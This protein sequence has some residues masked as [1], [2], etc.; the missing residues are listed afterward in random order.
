V[1]VTAGLPKSLSGLRPPEVVD[2]DARI[3]VAWHPVVE[4]NWRERFVPNDAVFEEGERVRVITGPNMSGKSTYLR[5]VAL[6]ALLAQI[7]SCVPARSARLGLTD[8][9][10]TR[11]GA[12]DEIFAGQSTFMVEMV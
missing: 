5:Q 4:N 8:R 7:G 1:D 6:I 9:I 10:F 11:M 12:Q 3:R 2:E